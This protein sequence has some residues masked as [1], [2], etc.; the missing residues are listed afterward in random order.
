MA[1]S[2]PSFPSG[3][4]DTNAGSGHSFVIPNDVNL[5]V[6]PRYR[7]VD[8]LATNVVALQLLKKFNFNPKGIWRINTIFRLYQCFSC[9]AQGCN[10]D[11]K[12]TMHDTWCIALN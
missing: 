8:L 7:R 10:S 6:R 3:T 1:E 11:V 4:D 9:T 5:S 12:D 2:T